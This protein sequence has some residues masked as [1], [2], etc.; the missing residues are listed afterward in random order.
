MLSDL[1]VYKCRLKI[2]TDQD[3]NM[4]TSVARCVRDD[5][6]PSAISW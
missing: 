5:A 4:D 6:T 2:K 1:H 3:V